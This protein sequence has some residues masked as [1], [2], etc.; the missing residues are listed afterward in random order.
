MISLIA[1]DIFV[2]AITPYKTSFFILGLPFLRSINPLLFFFLFFVFLDWRFCI[3]F[4]VV[5]F[6]YFLKRLI[7]K[8]FRLTIVT[9]LIQTIIYYLIYFGLCKIIVYIF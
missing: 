6:I 2:N 7:G 5:I 4:I 3:N 8:H 1:L 9:Y